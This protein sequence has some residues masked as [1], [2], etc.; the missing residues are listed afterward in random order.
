MVAAFASAFEIAE[1]LDDTD[2]RL[3][4]LWGS[5][6]EHITSLRYREAL[7][8]AEKFCTYVAKSADPEALLDL[9]H[10]VVDEIIEVRKRLNYILKQV[11]SGLL[12]SPVAPLL[13]CW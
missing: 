4:A 11:L 8:V 7:A 6:M 3:R 12:T 2:Y 1:S 10:D 13:E 5:F 9:V